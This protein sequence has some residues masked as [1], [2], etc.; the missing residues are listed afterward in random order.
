LAPSNCDRGLC[1][2][3]IRARPFR[4]V[5]TALNWGRPGTV[6]VLFGRASYLPHMNPAEWMLEVTSPAAEAELGLD[7]AMVWAAS[8][9]A[10]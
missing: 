9:Q 4:R 5:V 10:R 8:K 3:D 1:P 7:F 6:V 2:P